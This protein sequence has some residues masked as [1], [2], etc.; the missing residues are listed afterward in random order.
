METVVEQLQKQNADQFK[1]LGVLERICARIFGNGDDTGTIA[2]RMRAMEGDMEDVKAYI[3][4]QRT[5]REVLTEIEKRN[6]RRLVVTVAIMSAV[7]GG[8]SV[9][10]NL[11]T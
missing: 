8:A 3:G 5:I 4:E 2:G 7:I 11:L 9:L 6:N 10:V 1:R